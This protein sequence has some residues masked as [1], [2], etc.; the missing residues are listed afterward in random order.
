VDIGVLH[1]IGLGWMR[2]RIGLV[3]PTWGAPHYR[4]L[5]AALNIGKVL[6]LDIFMN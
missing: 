5:T 6:N 2:S 4:V 3:K 1:L